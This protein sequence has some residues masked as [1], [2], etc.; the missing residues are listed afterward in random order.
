MLSVDYCYFHYLMFINQIHLFNSYYV[1][2][3]ENI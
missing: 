1:I 3:S 2:D